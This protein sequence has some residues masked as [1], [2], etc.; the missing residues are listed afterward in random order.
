MVG[1][2][3]SS[4]I[5]PTSS[6]SPQG[7]ARRI[8]FDEGRR[9]DQVV[10]HPRV[11][12]AAF[13]AGGPQGASAASRQ[14]LAGDHVADEPRAQARSFVS[15]RACS[16]WHALPPCL[17]GSDAPKKSHV[18]RRGSVIACADVQATR[19]S[20]G[21]RPMSHRQ[22]YAEGAGSARRRLTSTMA[23]RPAPSSAIPAGSGTRSEVPPG[24]MKSWL[25]PLVS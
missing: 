6:F 3:G 18:R 21:C 14:M 1:V 20:G 13:G 24:V 8:G 12:G 23:S 2:V 15:A 19:E 17:D 7:A 5:A 22:L 11:S 9:R 4:P 25:S 16:A 10:R